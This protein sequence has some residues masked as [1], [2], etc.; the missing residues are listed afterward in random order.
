MRRKKDEQGWLEFQPSNLKLT[1]EYYARYE[2][3][4]EI[5]DESPRLLDFVHRDLEAAL[6]DENRESK[7]R[8][9]FVYTSEMVLRLALC[10]ILEGASLR[11]IVVRVDDSHCLR[12]FTRIHAGPMMG[13]T[14]L[15]RL[16]NA[17]QP[18][19]WKAMNWLLA[20][21][22]VT[23]EWITGDELRLDTTAVETNIH[24]PTD[25]SLL[26]DVYRTIGRLIDETRKICPQAIGN[27][28]VH[29]RRTKRLAAKI[30]RKAQHKGRRARDVKPLYKRLIAS[31]EGICDWSEQVTNHIEKMLRR[32]RNDALSDYIDMQAKRLRHFDALGRQAIWQATERVLN[33]RQVPNEN[34]I[35][36]I[37]EEHTELLKRGKAGKDVE[38]GHMIQIQQTGEKFITD[39]E[40]FDHKPA[41]PTL[42]RPALKSHRKLFG[43]YPES[44]ATDKGYWSGDEF[45]KISAE[46]EIVSIPKKGRRN[47]ME[48]EREL[49]PLFRLAQAFRAGVEGSI[50]FLKRFLRLARCLNKGWT[51]YVSTVGATVFAHNLLVLARC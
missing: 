23:S 12:R 11:G 16:R 9:G 45:E 38:F 6:E 2:S 1:N 22:A 34:K 51:N 4:S 44:L 14:A 19:T 10:Q 8:G 47:D 17:I 39:Y 50:S 18:E 13:H 49:D 27:G 7:R 26:W 24:W 32:T 36:S 33:E 48:Q 21:K 3:I 41:E 15:C 28:R 29:L 20:Q 30:A 46:V 43:H 31:V 5:L 42:I 37:F 25:S 35:F 40:V